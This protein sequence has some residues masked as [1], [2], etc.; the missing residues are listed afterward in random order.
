MQMSLTLITL[1]PVIGI[2]LATAW[3][4]AVFIFTVLFS[5]IADGVGMNLVFTGDLRHSQPV[6]QFGEDFQFDMPVPEIVELDFDGEE[7]NR[8][9]DHLGTL[10]SR[11]YCG[12]DCQFREGKYRFGIV[13]VDD[14]RNS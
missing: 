12:F 6:V 8:Y 4:G 13:S 10:T 7:I 14:K 5:P 9:R 11:H 1:T 3:K 2:C